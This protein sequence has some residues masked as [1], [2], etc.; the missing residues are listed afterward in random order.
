[1]P[2]PGVFAEATVTIVSQLMVY[3][4][5]SV[6][7]FFGPLPVGTLAMAPVSV[8]FGAPPLGTFSAAPVCVANA[9]VVASVAPASAAPG[10]MF[11]LTLTGA[12]FTGATQ[13]IFVLNGVADTAFTVGDVT[14]SVNGTSLTA[15]VTIGAS[16]ASGER[17]VIVATPAGSST[18]APIG[19]NS[20]TVM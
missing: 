14:P 16:V 18:G 19:T 11:M 7:A 10:S 5:D 15:T 9:P 2:F 12:N 13:V 17:I 20:F 1:V 4:E 8:N 6:G 3:V